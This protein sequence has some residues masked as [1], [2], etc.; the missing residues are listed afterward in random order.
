MM[1]WIFLAVAGA[2]GF[3]FVSP[4]L[5]SFSVKILPNA[6]ASVQKVTMALLGGAGVIVAIYIAEQFFGGKVKNI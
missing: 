1:E 3:A 5:Q 2:A 4:M 6:S